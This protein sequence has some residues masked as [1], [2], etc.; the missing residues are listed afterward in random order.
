[1]STETKVAKNTWQAHRTEPRR[2]L[3]C[4][5]DYFEVK[6]VKNAYMKENIGLV[7]KDLALKQ[8]V[9][10]KET[11]D[12]L[13]ERK[14]LDEVLIIK[15]EEGLE[16][17]VFAANQSFPWEINGKKVVLM[18][19]MKHKNRQNEV[20][21]FK[22]FYESQ[23]YKIIELSKTEHF[24]GMG[25]I[26]PH[27]GKNLL[28][29]GYGH[30]SD[31]N[32]YQEI[33]EIPEVPVVTLKLVNEG[34]YHLDTCFL[35]IDEETVFIAKLAFDEEGIEKIHKHFKKV[36]EIPEQ[37]AKNFAL[38]AHCITDELLGEKIA[39]LQK[40]TDITKRELQKHGF[41]IIEIDTSEF[42]KSGGSVFCMKMMV[43]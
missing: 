6:D 18:S 29:G 22:I 4:S 27:P 13:V 12:G 24:E 11:Y 26:I 16:D 3:L 8:W 17:M 21:Y 2:V 39:V 23:G 34:F 15:G 36:V 10:L 31:K 9:T 33:S 37:E 43:F 14:F 25:D 40:G 35:P 30:R 28:Y 20:P 42:I 41:E 38:N 32:A 19:K 7:D 5:P 1:V